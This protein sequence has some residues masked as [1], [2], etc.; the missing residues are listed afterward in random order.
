MKTVIVDC[1]NI[2]WGFHEPCYEE[3]LKFNPEFPKPEDWI[4]WEIF[5][6]HLSEANMF[7]MF[8]NTYERILEYKPYGGAKELLQWLNERY[9]VVIATHGHTK[10]I[11]LLKQWLDVNCLSYNKIDVSDDKTVLFDKDCTLV[12]DDSPHT[13]KVAQDKGIE[14]LALAYPWNTLSLCNRFNDLYELLEF[15]K[16]RYEKA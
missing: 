11:S 15:I 9:Y 8:D 10:T 4:K 5:R 12:I 1:D 3:C 2:L 13:I 6:D 7:K 16:W 14:V